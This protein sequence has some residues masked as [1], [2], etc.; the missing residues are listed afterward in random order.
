MKITNE[1]FESFLNCKYKA[2]LKA[3]AEVETLTN[4][5]KMSERLLA[6]S[7]DVYH[8][9]LSSKFSTK[10]FLDH[11]VLSLDTLG[12]GYDYLFNIITVPLRI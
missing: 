5:G 11:Y 6:E 2:Y 7:K 3:S 1:I 12:I 9:K 8:K 10:R 4:Y